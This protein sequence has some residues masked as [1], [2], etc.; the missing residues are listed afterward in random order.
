[1]TSRAQECPLSRRAVAG[2]RLLLSLP[3]E[4]PHHPTGTHI[5]GLEAVPAEGVF[6]VLTHHLGTAFV[7]L[8]VDLALGAA[9]DWRVI[10]VQ[11][12]SRAEAGE[13]LSGCA[14]RLWGDLP[15]KAT[16]ESRA[17]VA[18]GLRLCVCSVVSNPLRPQGLS[19]TRPLC[20]GDFPNKD[21]GVGCYEVTCY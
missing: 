5:Q 18:E 8:N 20:P 17:Q 15:A 19:P 16:P 6:A 1:M 12:E 13:T 11:L 2:P 10:L 3:H 21:T 4:A 7:P 9:L 14:R